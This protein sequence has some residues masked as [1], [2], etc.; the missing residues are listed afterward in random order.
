VAQAGKTRSLSPLVYIVVAAFI[1]F[2]VY[3]VA[4]PESVTGLGATTTQSAP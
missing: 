3:V 4:N 1:L 2:G